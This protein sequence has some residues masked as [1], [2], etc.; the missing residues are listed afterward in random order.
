MRTFMKRLP[1]GVNWVLLYN[2]SMEF[3][4]QDVQT[5]SGTVHEVR[6][7]VERF[8]KYPDTDLFD[9]YP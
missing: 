8:D 2:A 9:E 1:S 7:L 5:V 4:P 3:D 6:R